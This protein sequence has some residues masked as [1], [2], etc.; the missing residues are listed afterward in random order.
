MRTFDTGATRDGDLDKYDYEGFL[1]PLVVER[2]A[3]YMN[4]NRIQSDGNLRDGDNWQKGIPLKSYMKSVWRHLM[5]WW[6]IHRGYAD[7]SELEDAI[8]GV[9]FNAQGYLHEILKEKNDE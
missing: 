1:C 9:I 4:K 6:K 8:C 2:F 7:K 3:K 5:L